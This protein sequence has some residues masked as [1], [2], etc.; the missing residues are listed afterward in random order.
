MTFLR[1][2]L[3]TPFARKWGGVIAFATVILFLSNPELLSV[4]LLVNMIGVD[5]FVL[6]IGLQLK[7]HWS[8][9]SM[10]IIGPCLSRLRRLLKVG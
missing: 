10:F 6:L 5:V 7:Q 4:V 2:R 3:N 1:G 8:V 9:I